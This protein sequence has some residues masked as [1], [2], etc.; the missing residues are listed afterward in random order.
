MKSKKT[1]LITSLSTLTATATAVPI[2]V[3]S[4]ATTKNDVNDDSIGTSDAAVNIN[5]LFWNLAPSFTTNE[6]DKVTAQIWQ[7]NASLVQQYST[8]TTYVTVDIT[9]ETA[10]TF[11]VTLTPDGTNFSGNPITW[12]A[13]YITSTKVIT[14]TTT[15]E[16]PATLQA[17]GTERDYTLS[18]TLEGTT[19]DLSQCTVTAETS[20]EEVMTAEIKDS[21]ATLALTPKNGAAI[22][23]TITVA[24]ADKT[25]YGTITSSILVKATQVEPIA[26]EDL[27]TLK[28]NN[29]L[30][31]GQQYRINDFVTTTN[32]KVAG[33]S[34]G[35]GVVAGKSAGHPFDIVVTATSS[36]TLSEDATVKPRAGES[37]FDGC[38][39]AAWQIKYCLENDTVHYEWADDTIDAQ[40]KHN[41][42]GVIYWM[43]DEFNNECSYD[44]KNIKF[45]NKDTT[46][47]DD[48][49]YTFSTAS[50]GGNDL[51][52]S[53][54]ATYFV[55]DNVIKPNQIHSGGKYFLQVNRIHFFGSNI[56]SNTIGNFSFA[57]DFLNISGSIRSNEIGDSFFNNSVGS[58]FSYNKV[59]SYRIN[60]T[61]GN[62]ITYSTFGS[63]KNT[64]TNPQTFGNS[65]TECEFGN[66][67]S[68]L[69]VGNNVSNCSVGNDCT[70]ITIGNNVT[71]TAIGDSCTNINILNQTANSFANNTIKNGCKYLTFNDVNF[72][73]NTI[74]DTSGTSANPITF[75]KARQDATFIN[76]VE[77][78]QAIKSISYKELYALVNSKD[79]V[80]GQQYRIN[81]YTATTN[82][83]LNNISSA[84]NKFDVIVTATSTNTFS[85]NAKA[86]KNAADT[87]FPATTKFDAWEIKYC[88]GNDTSRFSWA[89]SQL[90]AKGN[91][92]GKGV[93]YYMKDEFGNEVGYDFKN[94]QYK[95]ESQTYFTFA[96]EGETAGTYVDGSLNGTTNNIRD[97]KIASYYD[98]TSS[99]YALNEIYFKGKNVYNNTFDK[100]CRNI[101]FDENS[102]GIANVYKNT[103][104]LSCAENT[105]GFNVYTNTFDDDFIN[106]TVC[107][108]FRGNTFGKMCSN[109]IFN[110]GNTEAAD[111][112][113]VTYVYNNTFG[114]NIKYIT[115]NVNDKVQ[116]N[117]N[118]IY[119]TSNIAITHSCVN[120]YINNGSVVKPEQN[121]YTASMLSWTPTPTKDVTSKAQLVLST[122]Y[123]Y[124]KISEVS[125]E[126]V[127]TQTST[128]LAATVDDESDILSITPTTNGTFNLVVNAKINNVVVATLSETV[129]VAAA[130]VNTMTIGSG[131]QAGTYTLSSTISPNVFCGSTYTIPLAESGSITITDPTTITELKLPQADTSIT[132]IS[133][134]FLK[135]TTNLVHLDLSG[136]ASVTTIGNNFL[137][138]SSHLVALDLS[139]L[140]ALTSIGE[141]FCSD[142]SSLYL[143]IAPNQDPTSVTTSNVNFLGGSTFLSIIH[144]GDYVTQYKQ[145]SPWSNFA[146]K[147]VN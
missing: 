23:L 102:S 58:G 63:M 144:A 42:K 140:T 90:D 12:T 66:L 107:S 113:A 62:S 97:N 61:F 141:N 111:A 71:G 116:F 22:T 68:A 143:L 18:A 15:P 65:I 89:D 83:N 133:N 114:T 2:A 137:S 38:N 57:C 41:G 21:N 74:I 77:Q 20:N 67:C 117:N 51:D 11:D 47:G 79:L 104:G 146:N 119:N 26:Y 46:T 118:T 45:Y 19:L 29:N 5:D 132:S 50:A 120:Q 99:S 70:T 32:G 81:D 123:G 112:D 14:I 60:T 54:S 44:F 16:I 139:A 28:T 33:T 56:F 115:V 94:I 131:A 126:V 87:Y 147:I 27:L 13:Q 142:M 80:V 127:T 122:W 130:A 92:T 75:N 17:D 91:P 135:G 78:P 25:G 30:V 101:T 88:F 96:V 48:Y 129:I 31:E 84:N 98:A 136:L 49:Y 34:S 52:T 24:N 40:G 121:T 106:N 73:N 1:K 145:T 108:N 110:N 85:E 105:F 8:I 59:S 37:Y 124:V 36:N 82:I 7:D 6:K 93:I 100:G 138:G 109:N 64:D 35:A 95:V 3:T 43:K 134:D 10:T 55:H 103:F 128:E 69:T 4:C 9:N 86:I 72:S 39:L 76:G 53:L 125:W